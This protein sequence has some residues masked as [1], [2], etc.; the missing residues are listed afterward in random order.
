M[1]TEP[2][3]GSH[4]S[5]VKSRRLPA[6]DIMRA[7]AAT[8]VFIFH[9]S[10]FSDAFTVGIPAIDFMEW[11]AA[12]LGN[13]GTNLL[14]LLSG[15]FI[16]Q[17]IASGRFTYQR[18]VALRL[19]RIVL[20]YLVVL[21][22]AI[23]AGRF[24]PRFSRP[25][26]AEA[27]FTTFL[28]QLLLLPGLFPDVPILTVSWTLS[29]IIAGYLVF[30]VV[31]LTLLHGAAPR[32]RRLLVWSLVTA[33]I[34]LCGLADGPLSI[35]FAY[36]PAGCLVFEIQSD[37]ASSARRSGVLRRLL[38]IAAVF[39]F[40]RVTLDGDILGTAWLPPLRKAIYTLSGLALTATLIGVALI[41]QRRYS[42]LGEIRLLSLTAGYGRTGY[43]FYLL[44][45]PVVKVFALLLF[46]LFAAAN[47]PALLYWLVMPVCWAI[48]AAAAFLL[49]RLVERPCRGF[50]MAPPAVPAFSRSGI[51]LDAPA[52]FPAS[53][54]AHTPARRH[55]RS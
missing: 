17:S 30:P 19:S 48:A 13:I 18:F 39:L 32:P 49:Y 21:L 46:P 31:A 2:S 8:L 41:V 54:P 29:Y 15:F 43:S 27:S 6:F 23:A 42:W 7:C 14:L 44:H 55:P 3:H 22:M 33:F 45:G 40:L 16:A 12:R 38:A 1:T 50:L 9:Y 24:Y 10:G 11:F 28:A 20:P 51:R 52:P 5:S 37:P 4:D 34:F 47:A 53:P 35:R 26:A 25:E 36:V